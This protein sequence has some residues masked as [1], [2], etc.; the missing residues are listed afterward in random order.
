MHQLSGVI[1]NKHVLTLRK[2][3]DYLERIVAADV[4]HARVF[5]ARE[6]Y[7]IKAVLLCAVE[8]ADETP[9]VAKND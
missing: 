6:L 3:A 2:R 4:E 9:Q 7:A 8:V 1:K 5:Q